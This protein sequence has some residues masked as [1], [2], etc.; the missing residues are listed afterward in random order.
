M[1]HQIR[2]TMMLLLLTPVALCLALVLLV[3]DRVAI[4]LRGLC[5]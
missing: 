1:L 2:L 5:Q 3:V 4:R